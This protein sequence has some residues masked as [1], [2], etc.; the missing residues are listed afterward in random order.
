MDILHWAFDN[1]TVY[2]NNVWVH[3][4]IV[5][6][7]RSHKHPLVYSWKGFRACSF[8]T[9]QNALSY[10]LAQGK[11]WCKRCIV[12][13]SVLLNNT[14]LLCICP[15]CMLNQMVNIILYHCRYLHLISV[16]LVLMVCFLWWFWMRWLKVFLGNERAGRAISWRMFAVEIVNDTGTQ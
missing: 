16:V 7:F 11:I 14:C 4:F 15:A 1:N 10:K 12:E 3:L 9:F 6:C 2:S 8:A 13:A 5:G